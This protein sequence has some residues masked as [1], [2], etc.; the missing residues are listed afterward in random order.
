MYCQYNVCVFCFL[1]CYQYYRTAIAL[2]SHEQ[3]SIYS[4]MPHDCHIINQYSFVIIT[5]E[6]IYIYIIIIV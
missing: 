4:N 5:V 1:Y 6:Y 3:Y 2:Y